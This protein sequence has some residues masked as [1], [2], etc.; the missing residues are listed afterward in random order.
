VRDTLSIDTR[1]ARAANRYRR[2]RVLVP[3]V[4]QVVLMLPALA[5]AIVWPPFP[6]HGLVR[7]V[8]VPGLAVLGGAAGLLFYS[9]RAAWALDRAPL[10]A[11]N[12]RLAYYA[13]ALHRAM[14]NPELTDRIEAV[15]MLYLLGDAAGKAA[16][17]LGDTIPG[18]VAEDLATTAAKD[19]QRIGDDIDADLL[20]VLLRIEALQAAVRDPAGHP[21]PDDLRGPRPGE[22]D[23]LASRLDHACRSAISLATLALALTRRGG[24]Q[25]QPLT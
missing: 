15:R 9:E 6:G 12:T 11:A 3:V 4:G 10:A 23:D 22:D 7:S 5:C 24:T 25:A 18:I 8:L 16:G 17:D 20:G 21:F 19:A 13:L 1:V 2:R 14:R